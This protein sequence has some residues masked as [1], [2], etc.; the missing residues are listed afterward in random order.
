MSVV[1]EGGRNGS[2]VDGALVAEPEV[3]PLEVP[4]QVLAAVSSVQD[5]LQRPLSIHEQQV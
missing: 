3:G 4:T 1:G 2:P 5:E